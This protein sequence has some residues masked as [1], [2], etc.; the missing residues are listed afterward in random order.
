MAQST[1]ADRLLTHARLCRQM[2]AASLDENIAEKLL[3]M[4][5]ACIEVVAENKAIENLKTR[6]CG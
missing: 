2:A 3:R 4:A 1:V 5:E 6:Q